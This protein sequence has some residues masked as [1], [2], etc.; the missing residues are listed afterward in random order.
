M[1]QLKEKIKTQQIKGIKKRN[2]FTDVKQNVSVVII[3]ANALKEG[4][5]NAHKKLP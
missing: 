1:S 2:C 3:T 5:L 4:N